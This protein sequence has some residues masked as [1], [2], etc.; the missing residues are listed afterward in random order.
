MEGGWRSRLTVAR[1]MLFPSPSLLRANY[2]VSHAWQI[3]LYYLYRPLRFLTR[4]LPVL[5]R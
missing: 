5:G 2:G 3:P 1:W 4:R